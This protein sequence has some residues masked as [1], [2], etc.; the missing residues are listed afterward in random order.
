MRGYQAAIVDC[1][2]AAILAAV[3]CQAARYLGWSVDPLV[4][5]VAGFG[6]AV[7]VAV[8]SVLLPSAGEA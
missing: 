2:S 7:I 4:P 8:L 1:W 6:A 5:L 3:L